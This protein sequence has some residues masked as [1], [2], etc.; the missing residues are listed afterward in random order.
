[1]RG[2][3]FINKTLASWLGLLEMNWSRTRGGRPYLQQED[4]RRKCTPGTETVDVSRRELNGRV[5]KFLE[6][7]LTY[8]PFRGRPRRAVFSEKQAIFP[9]G[10]PCIRTPSA[11]TLTATTSCHTHTHTH[12]QWIVYASFPSSPWG[13]WSGRRPEQNE[14]NKKVFG[15]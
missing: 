12:K 2:T 11:V 4:E 5:K 1:M 13:W 15:H 10:L 14:K 6:I 7:T 9:R 3:Q 8:I